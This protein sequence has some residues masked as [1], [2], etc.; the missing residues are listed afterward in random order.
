MV[1]SETEVKEKLSRTTD[2][3]APDSLVKAPVKLSEMD[4]ALRWVVVKTPKTKTPKLYVSLCFRTIQISFVS[5]L[6]RGASTLVYEV[7]HRTDLEY[8]IFGY[9]NLFEGRATKK[10][11]CLSVWRRLNRG[12]DC[13]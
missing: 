4:A 9:S 5:P 7:G 3:A 12:A 2:P 11:S 13:H 6:G 1:T 10:V 8:D